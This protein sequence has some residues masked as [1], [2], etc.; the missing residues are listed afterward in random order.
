MLVELV[1]LKPNPMRDLAI[2]PLD[3][4]TVERLTKSIQE[5]E[6]WGGVV[7]RKRPDGVVEV[8]AGWH[9][10]NAAI[11]AGMT[12]AEIFI[13]DLDDAG[14]IRVY[15]TENATQRG[16][17]STAVA[18]TVAAAFRFIVKGILT[19]RVS[20]EITG[21]PLSRQQVEGNL[22]SGRGI[23][24]DLIERFLTDVPSINSNIIREQLA[25]LR[26]SGDYARIVG[27][28]RE[29]IEEENKVAL[30]ELERREQEAA[31]LRVEQEEAEARQREAEERKREAEMAAKAAKEEAD[32]KRAAAEQE[33][34]E[35]ERE[36][37]EALAQLAEKRRLESEEQLKQFDALRVTRDLSKEAAEAIASD[38][39]NQRVF[40]FE[41]V[42]RYLHT[43]N[44]I[45]T[46]RGL[47]IG[48]GIKPFLSIEQQAPLAARLVE[49][50][51]ENGEEVTS[52]FLRE[53]VGAMVLAIR[54]QQR[55]M[56]KKEEAEL[57]RRDWQRRNKALQQ[58]F[59]QHVR[60][61]VR[62][63]GLL[64]EHDD[65]RPRG[66]AVVIE[67]SLQEAAADLQKVIG[68]FKKFRLL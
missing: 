46:F 7:G 47:V 33:A 38:E 53:N 43:P 13:A 64:V 22:L 10:V 41:G 63:A 68:V 52:R 50:A 51:R 3:L 37:A 2:D 4:A 26:S 42:A 40:D 6:F 30:L 18:G 16:N 31:R 1:S 19:G 9:R 44:H 56:K 34:A 25:I 62:I 58:E 67:R 27:E 5:H 39:K 23:G 55:D 32:R 28:V 65:M 66:V 11:Q 35:L 57:Q 15:A 49:R 12:S 14:M 36:R 54:N 61:L 20:R 8:A 24:A 60:A 59:A 29:E 21:N 48:D 45:A 17:S